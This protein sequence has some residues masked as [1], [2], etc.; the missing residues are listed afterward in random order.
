M[1][2]QKAAR[3][4]SRWWPPWPWRTRKRLH[5]LKESHKEAFRIEKERQKQEL[6]RRQADCDRRVAEEA[7]RTKGILDVI[8]SVEPFREDGPSN[9]TLRFGCRLSVDPVTIQMM[10]VG[11]DEWLKQAIIERLAADLRDK[12]YT[13]EFAALPHIREIAERKRFAIPTAAPRWGDKP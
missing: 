1:R 4:I 5:D 12:L 10:I 11:Q 7:A 9:Y 13:I 6:A 8:A 2:T 3:S